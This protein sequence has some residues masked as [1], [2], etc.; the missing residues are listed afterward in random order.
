MSPVIFVT[1]EGAASFS[2]AAVVALTEF[3]RRASISL[4]T[5][6]Q[7][8]SAM[9]TPTIVVCACCGSRLWA[10]DFDRDGWI[11]GPKMEAQYGGP[12]C[13]GCMDD[14]VLTQDTEKFLPKHQA[15]QDF[16]G[17]WWEVVPYG[18]ETRA[19]YRRVFGG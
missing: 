11:G 2:G 10:E 17:E 13:M 16:E 15:Y 1:R 9:N 3:R 14:L 4:H 5:P 8:G 6:H 19:D 12:V 18:Y 7:K